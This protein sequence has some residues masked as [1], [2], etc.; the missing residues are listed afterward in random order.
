[1]SA[2]PKGAPPPKPE[3]RTVLRRRRRKRAEPA[4]GAPLVDAALRRLGLAEKVTT[5]RAL[6]AFSRAAG[7]RLLRNARAER[8]AHHTLYIRVESSAWANQ[9]VFARQTLLD[10]LH[11]I[12][13][14]E[15]IQELRF[16]VGPL[17]DVDA[18]A[19]RVQSQ[20][21][22]APAPRLTTPVDPDMA[23][24]LTRVGDDELR[25]A[26]G[27]LYTTACRAG[28]PIPRKREA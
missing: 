5:F 12:P 19:L 11:K 13:G 24:A 7:P 20:P 16:S 8:Y 22:A 10:R 2:G 21:P 4:A 9:L 23:A 25:D 17:E 26:L 3:V 6:A 15:E 14:G 27:A 18:V 28:V 1:M